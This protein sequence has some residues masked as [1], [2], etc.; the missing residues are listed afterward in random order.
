MTEIIAENLQM[1]PRATGAG[2][3]SSSESGYSRPSPQQNSSQKDDDIPIIDEDT[4]VSSG[5]E[6]EEMK[7]SEKDIPF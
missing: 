4:D 7:V 2:G 6:E 3:F 1:G 5:V